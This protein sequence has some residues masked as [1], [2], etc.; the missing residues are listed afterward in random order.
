MRTPFGQAARHVSEF[1]IQPDD[2]HRQYGP[3]DVVTGSVVLK[4]AKPMDITHIVVC[5]HGFAQVY[6]SPNNPG[7]GYRSYNAA[8]V[9]GKTNKAGGYYGNGFVSLF[10]DEV[11]LCGDGRL[12]EGTYQFNFELQ[13]PRDHAPTSIEVRY[14]SVG[15]VVGS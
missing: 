1:Y 15:R 11:V 9:A 14:P 10:E 3:G 5:L 4:V 2:P 8:L 7:E 13:F 12:G 6:K